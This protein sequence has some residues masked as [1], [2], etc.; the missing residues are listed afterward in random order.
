VFITVAT[1]VAAACGGSPTSSGGAPSTPA[2]IDDVLDQAESLNGQRQVAF[3]LG[4]AK[5]EGGPLRSTSYSADS[6]D[7][8]VKAFEDSTAWMSRRTGRRR[9]SAFAFWDRTR[10]TPAPTSWRCAGRAAN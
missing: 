2:G 5:K 3:L 9:L 8:L 6:L 4:E 1:L 10:Y 7:A